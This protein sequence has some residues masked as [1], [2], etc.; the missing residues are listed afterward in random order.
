VTV[1]STATLT[2]PYGAVAQLAEHFHGMEGVVSSILISSTF[3]DSPAHQ[4]RG[5]SYAV[6]S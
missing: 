2:V 3:E 1:R 4:E 5:F 6:S